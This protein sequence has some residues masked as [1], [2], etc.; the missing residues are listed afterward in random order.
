[1]NAYIKNTSK[2]DQ[3]IARERCAWIYSG[4]PTTYK[5]IWEA[6]KNPSRAK[7]AAAHN[8]MA[9]CERL[10]GYDFVIYGA[11]CHTFTAAFKYR[12][13]G[14]RR[15]CYCYM[16]RDYWRYCY[17]DDGPAAIPA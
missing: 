5:T 12:E 1:M 2:A 14:T 8:C 10:H 17:A 13:R 15:E 3:R 16:T 7:W 9:H 4:R 6:Y 11:G